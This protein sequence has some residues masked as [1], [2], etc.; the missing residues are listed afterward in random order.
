MAEGSQGRVIEDGE[1]MGTGQTVEGMA[2]ILGSL[3][4]TL[5]DGL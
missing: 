2:G 4:F 3:G 1:V 5:N